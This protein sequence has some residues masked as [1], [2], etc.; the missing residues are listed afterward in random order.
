MNP[1]NNATKNHSLSFHN[2]VAL[3]GIDWADQKHALATLELPAQAEAQPELS[4]LEHKTEALMEWISSVQKRF[5]YGRIAIAIEQRKGALIHFLSAFDF[6]D[7]YPIEPLSMNNCRK[8]LYPSGAHSDPV[9]ATL[10]AE[11]LLKHHGR[12]RCYRA[13][14][15]EVRQ[16]GQYCEHRRRFVDERAQALQSLKASLK[17]YFPLALELFNDLSTSLA[18]AF[19]QRW[20]TLEKLQTARRASVRAFFYS[21]GSRSKKL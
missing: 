8:P 1:Q 7:I 6:I 5:C 2:Y 3:I 4:T 11:F 18:N 17:F 13:Q 10:L 12:L 21:H 19:L 16:C 14:S 9:D 20:P 15:V